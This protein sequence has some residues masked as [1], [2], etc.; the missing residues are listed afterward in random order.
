MNN[1]ELR[2][3][4]FDLLKSPE[5]YQKQE[6]LGKLPLGLVLKTL[7]SALCS[8]EE[9]IKWHAV[10][11]MGTITDDL[12]QRDLERAR[13]ILRRMIWSLN[14][15]SGGIGWGMPEAMGEILARNDTLAEEFFPLLLSYIRPGEN[16]LGLEL[17]QRGAL[18][19][20]GR[21]AEVHPQ[22]LSRHDLARF[23]V[24]YLDSPDPGVRGHA[25]W[26]AGLVGTIDLSK[27]ES[28]L[29]DEAEIGFYRDQ[30]L[31]TIRIRDLARQAIME[32]NAEKG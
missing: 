30:K 24:P 28:L 16:F 21:V 9:E 3:K 22:L 31:I 10:T 1:Q 12:A 4:I 29:H 27:L 25:V 15:E 18:W 6:L 2:K 20:I 11:A 23:L 13:N 7:F 17:L 14:E 8:N 26:A 19:G 5:F 32:H